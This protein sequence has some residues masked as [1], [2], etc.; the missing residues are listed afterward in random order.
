[1]NFLKSWKNENKFI[2]LILILILALAIFWPR[3]NGPNLSAGIGA[4][5]GNLRGSIEIEAFGSG[6]DKP[7]FVLF[8][9]P[10][11]GHCKRVMPAFDQLGE[12]YEGVSVVKV[13]C[14]ENPE[15]AK[16]HQIQGFPTLKFFR[17]GMTDPQTYVVYDG[18]RSLDDMKS[19][20]QSQ[21]HIK[22]NFDNI[23]DLPMPD[24]APADYNDSNIAM[25]DMVEKPKPIRTTSQIGSMFSQ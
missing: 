6:D 9:A 20:I 10:W 13:N 14:D 2:L 7:Q 17:N 15:A 19:F 22:E 24:S 5:L 1:M 8:Y 16:M 18:E 4:H 11:C 21:L 25:S 23:Q 12:Q 3:N